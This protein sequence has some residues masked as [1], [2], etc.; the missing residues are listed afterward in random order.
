MPATRPYK[1]RHT[2]EQRQAKTK[3]Y[4][5]SDPDKVMVIVEKHPKS[6]LPDLSNS[7]YVSIEAGS[8]PSKRF[9]SSKFAT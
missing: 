1:E 5:E 8:W 6:K 2:F 3:S 9:N 4:A 7:K